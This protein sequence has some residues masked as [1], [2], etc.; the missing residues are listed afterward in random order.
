M[1]SY[2]TMPWE[3]HRD[4]VI[5]MFSFLKT[6]HN[7]R[8]LL[9]ATYP[10]IEMEKF[11]HHNWKQFY[12]NLREILLLNAPKFLGKELIIRGLC[13]CKFCWG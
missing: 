13:G 1:S 5:Y 8:L 4:H 12:G 7:S 2:T 10:G 3:G 11:K 9:D 6:Y